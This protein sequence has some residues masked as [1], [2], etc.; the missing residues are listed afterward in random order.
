MRYHDNTYTYFCRQDLAGRWRIFRKP[1]DE[2][3]DTY[4]A[5]TVRLGGYDTV[6]AAQEALERAA[7]RRRWG[8]ETE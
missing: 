7:V 2:P 4:R 1:R 3:S 5:H 6:E 8:E